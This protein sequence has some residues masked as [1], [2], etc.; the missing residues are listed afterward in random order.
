V[1][2]NLRRTFVS[3]ALADGARKD[4]LRWIVSLR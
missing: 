4:V 2:T 1:C 3:L